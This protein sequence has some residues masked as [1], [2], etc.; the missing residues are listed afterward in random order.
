MNAKAVPNESVVSKLEKSLN[1]VNRNLLIDKMKEMLFNPKNTPKN[2]FEKWIILATKQDVKQMRNDFG[3]KTV[4][5]QKTLKELK[6]KRK[7]II[8]YDSKQHIVL[9]W[10]DVEKELQ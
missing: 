1:K 7:K 3:F 8:D 10:S 9:L 4:S 6:K 5:L 2:K